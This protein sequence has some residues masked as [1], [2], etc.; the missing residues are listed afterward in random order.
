MRLPAGEI[1]CFL[2]VVSEATALATAGD[3]TGG[4]QCLC[5]GKRRAQ[6]GADGGECWDDDQEA[7][8]DAALTQY[9][10]RWGTRT[11]DD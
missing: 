11:T 4:Q 10:E 2:T 9:R 6:D 5:L 1:D 7:L 8:W 3:V